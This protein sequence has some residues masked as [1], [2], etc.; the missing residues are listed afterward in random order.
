MY[1]RGLFRY[2]QIKKI[3]L[4][5]VLLLLD[6]VLF[7]KKKYAD[8]SCTSCVRSFNNVANTD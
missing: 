7:L 8:A 4:L 5:V 1:Y 3:L 6:H 2:V